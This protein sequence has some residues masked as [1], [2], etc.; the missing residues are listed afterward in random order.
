MDTSYMFL[1]MLAG[2]LL[3]FPVF[4]FFYWERSERIYRRGYDD[5]F[6]DATDPIWGEPPNPEYIER[7][8]AD[9]RKILDRARRKDR[10]NRLP[11]AETIRAARIELAAQAAR[12]AMADYTHEG[13]IRE[14]MEQTPDGTIRPKA[15]W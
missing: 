5:G 15:V 14:D 10:A 6:A 3:V 2:A 13:E 4:M 8:E 11:D 1:L 9:V 7:W 12:E